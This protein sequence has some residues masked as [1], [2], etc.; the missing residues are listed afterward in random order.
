[1]VNNEFMQTLEDENLTRKIAALSRLE[2]T[3][4]E[5]SLFTTQLKEIFQYIELLKKVD[6]QGV[7]PL[8]HPLDLATPFREDE[9]HVFPPAKDGK[10]KVLGSAPDVLY[11]GFKVP[12]IL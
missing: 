4:G 7:E 12:S 2:L 1:M 6:V 8:T 3:D 10:P 5:I 11:E 9:V